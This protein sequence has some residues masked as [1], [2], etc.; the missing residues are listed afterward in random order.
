[1]F[2]Q[3]SDPLKSLKYQ[4]NE[5]SR[6]NEYFSLL[7]VSLKQRHILYISVKKYIMGGKF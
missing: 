6:K 7:T 4:K 3:D 2:A 1:M 5:Y